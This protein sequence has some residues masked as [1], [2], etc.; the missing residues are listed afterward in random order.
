MLG[1]KLD[2]SLRTTGEVVIQVYA[3]RTGG[4]SI[5]SSDNANPQKGS[6]T[7]EKGKICNEHMDRGN[8][9]RESER[10]KPVQ[11]GGDCGN[12]TLLAQ[13][14]SAST[15]AFWKTGREMWE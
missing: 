12:K 9:E 4:R 10:Q 3:I 8:P 7:R 14:D 15:R 5:F 13:L 1:Q 2:V 6:R 11:G